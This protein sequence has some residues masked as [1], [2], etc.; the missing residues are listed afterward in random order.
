MS[1]TATSSPP[2][3]ATWTTERLELLKSHFAAGLTCRQIAADIGVSRNAVIGKLSRLNLTRGRGGGAE[4][5]D[6]PKDRARTRARRAGPREQYR[7]LV[8]T[9]AD[10]ESPI[11]SEVLDNSKQC[12]LLDLDDS[13]CRWPIDTPDPS[14][15]CF[16]GNS[17][18]KG[19]PYCPGH[20]RMAYRS[21]SAPRL[22]SG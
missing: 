8:A 17:P 20:S 6:P 16:C 1:P 13:R 7:M 22:A 10:V 21:T 15:V 3:S 4:R 18:I 14:Q 2:L 11:V 12:S 19:L 5:S 9:F